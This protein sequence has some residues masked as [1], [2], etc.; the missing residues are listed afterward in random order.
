MKVLRVELPVRPWPMAIVTLKNRTLSPVVER[1]IEIF[2]TSPDRCVRSGRV[3][4]IKQA[5]RRASCIDTSE[6]CPLGYG[7]D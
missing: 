1:L 5:D 3:T 2:G 7:V 4:T 6:R